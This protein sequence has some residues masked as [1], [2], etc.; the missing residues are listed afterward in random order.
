MKHQGQYL[1]EAAR[2]A[3]ATVSDVLGNDCVELAAAGDRF[4][5]ENELS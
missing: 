5:G 4:L 3:V 1:G 2:A